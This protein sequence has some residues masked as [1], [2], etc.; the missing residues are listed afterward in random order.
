[1][2]LKKY[3]CGT[4]W[5]S[6]QGNNVDATALLG[7]SEVLAVKHT[8]RDAIPEFVQRLEYDREVS[9][10]VASEKAV[11]VFDDNGSWQ[12]SSN[13]AHKVMKESR[14]APA[15][16]RARPHARQAEVLARESGCPNIGRRDVCI[17]D[18]S[19]VVFSWGPRPVLLKDVHAEWLNLTLKGNRETGSFEPKIQSAYSSEERCDGMPHILSLALVGA[20]V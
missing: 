7:D 19:D 9:S 13:E 15:K 20:P 10:S 1:L 2:G 8:P 11:H 14:L 5:V 3:F 12:A 16:P 18:L 17:A 4:G 6:M